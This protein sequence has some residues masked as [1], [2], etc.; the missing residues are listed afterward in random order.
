MIQQKVL[1]K[2]ILFWGVMGFLLFAGGAEAAP[3]KSGGVFGTAYNTLHDTFENARNLVYVL[4]G[5]GLIGV[6]VGGI[7]GKVDFKWLA[8]IAI[9]LATLAGADKIVDYSIN[10]GVEMDKAYKGIGEDDFDLPLQ[11]KN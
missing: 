7:M 2:S 1:F 5:F 9:A 4:S 6:A 3:S 8:M 11:W 10:N